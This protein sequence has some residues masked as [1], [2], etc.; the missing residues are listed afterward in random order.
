MAKLSPNAVVEGTSYKRVEVKDVT[1]VNYK[2][3]CTQHDQYRDSDVRKRTRVFDITLRNEAGNGGGITICADCLDVIMA[4]AN[5]LKKK[6]IRK[7]P[8][9]GVSER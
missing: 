1:A 2:D 3:C 6:R 4:K 7:T 8:I 5:K 9:K